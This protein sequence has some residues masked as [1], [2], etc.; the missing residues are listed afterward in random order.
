MLAVAA[1]SGAGKSTVAAFA[2]AAGWQVQGDDLLGLTKSGNIVPLPGSLRVA[3]DSAPP[4]WT[5]AAD[6]ADGR[7]WY[8]LPEPGQPSRLEAVVRLARG[9]G[10]AVKAVTGARRLAAVADTGL[11]TFFGERPAESGP[12]YLLDLAA[13]LPVWELTVPEGLPSMRHA[14]ARIDSLLERAL[15]G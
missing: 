13:S 4:G 12:G 8:A 9:T 6:L 7:R 11:L 5:A 1:G 2:A 10:T 3:P 15:Q 14:W